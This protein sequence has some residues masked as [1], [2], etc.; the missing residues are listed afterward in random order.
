MDA[1]STAQRQSMRTARFQASALSV[2]F[3]L[4]FCLLPGPQAGRAQS[5][6]HFVSAQGRDDQARTARMMMHDARQWAERGL[7]QPAIKLARRAAE[8]SVEWRADEQTPQELLAKLAPAS[9]TPPT[10][11]TTQQPE[12]QQLKTQPE[13]QAEPHAQVQHPPQPTEAS[14]ARF[15][16][17][18]VPTQTTAPT[19]HSAALESTAVQ[20]ASFAAPATSGDERHALAPAAL[21]PA[22]LA[23]PTAQIHV[24]VDRVDSPSR[25]APPSQPI[26]AADSKL[27]TS[28]ATMD[29]SPNQGVQAHVLAPQAT[30]LAQRRDVGVPMNGSSTQHDSGPGWRTIAFALC[31]VVALLLFRDLRKSGG[32]GFPTSYT[33]QT[34]AAAAPSADQP[35]VSPTPLQEP[36][37]SQPP[38]SQPPVSPVPTAMAP[39]AMTPAEV[40]PRNDVAPPVRQSP[41]ERGPRETAPVEP[42]PADPTPASERRRPSLFRLQSR[43]SAD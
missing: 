27:R 2:L 23:T 41:A 37:V 33:Q 10:A 17:R 16:T 31:A 8:L 30:A 29:R 20:P 1:I 14:N 3:C 21:A 13:S 42:T 40:R 39:T 9:P 22:A 11:Q 34:I 12:P 6:R 5:P 19:P 25:V 7:M 38:V 35:H 28:S 26:A 15:T 36:P 43:S 32:S 18:L 24:I 4:T